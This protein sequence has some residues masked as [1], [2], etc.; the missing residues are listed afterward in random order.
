MFEQVTRV[1]DRTTCHSQEPLPVVGELPDLAEY[2]CPPQLSEATDASRSAGLLSWD[3]GGS[4]ERAAGELVPQ[5]DHGADTRLGQ[6]GTVLL[7]AR[8]QGRHGRSGRLLW[9]A[10]ADQTDRTE[11]CLDGRYRA[12]VCSA[13]GRSSRDRHRRRDRSAAENC[14]RLQRD[15]GAHSAARRLRVVAGR[16]P[17]DTPVATRI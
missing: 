3:G 1:A 11:R 2:A 5:D 15:R 6:L 14:H 12:H 8:I 9:R 13:G 17:A 10:I 4:A 7:L 16:P